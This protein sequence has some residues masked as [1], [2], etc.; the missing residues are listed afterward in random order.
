MKKKVFRF[1][2][3]IWLCLMTVAV[4]MNKSRIDVYLIIDFMVLVFN[5]FYIFMLIQCLFNAY[6]M[7]IQWLFHFYPN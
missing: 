7:L 5:C 4:V 3:I 2:V 1:L 6:S